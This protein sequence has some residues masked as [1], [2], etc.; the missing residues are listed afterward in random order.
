M[1][2]GHDGFLVWRFQTQWSPCMAQIGSEQ[3]ASHVTHYMCGVLCF[4]LRGGPGR[5]AHASRPALPQSPDSS[6]SPIECMWCVVV[7]EHCGLPIGVSQTQLS[8]CMV[9]L[10]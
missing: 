9:C 3:A 1:G 10:K 6:T 8:P 5:D 4:V 7:L 2:S